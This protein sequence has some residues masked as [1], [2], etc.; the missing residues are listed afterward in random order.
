MFD[1][2]LATLDRGESAAISLVGEAGIGKTRLL[3]ELAR[4][5]DARGHVV[6]SGSG[7]DLEGD[8]PFRVFVDAMDDYL[9]SLESHSLAEL[10]APV[11]AELAT[12]FPALA[13]YA[14]GREVGLQQ[15]RYRS[16]RAVRELLA[17]LGGNRPLVL[18]LDDVHWADPGSIE[19]LTTMLHRPLGAPVLIASA[20]R[21]KQL[22][23]RLV[24]TMARAQRSGLLAVAELASFS[25]AE[26]RTFLGDALDHD[27]FYEESGGNPF[28][29]EQLARARHR[30]GAEQVGHAG[31]SLS[32][33]PVPSSVIASLVEELGMLSPDTRVVLDGASVVGD[34]FEPELAAAA[35]AVPDSAALDAI[36]ELLDLDLIRHTELPRRFRFRHPLMRRAVYESTRG[37]WRLAAHGRLAQALAALGA[38]PASRAHHVEYSAR[39]GDQAAIR[40]LREAG[41][42]TAARAPG[43]AARWFA[44]ALRLLGDSGPAPERVELRQSLAGAQ[45]ATGHFADARATLVEALREV[46]DGATAGRIGLIAAC[47]GVEQLLGQHDL[48]HERLTAA[49]DDLDDPLSGAAAAL[50]IS[51]AQAAF[52]RQNVIESRQWSLRALEAAE[53]VPDL[54]LIAAAAA[55]TAIAYAFEG[56]TDD[57]ERYRH[58][59]ATLIDAMSDEQLS[60][61]LDAIASLAGAESYLD[62]FEDSFA[63]GTRGLRIARETSQGDLLPM[64]VQA[65]ATAML[66]SGRLRQAVELLDGSIEAARLAGHNQTLAWSLLNRAFVAIHQ[67]ALNAARVDAQESIELARALDDSV[68]LTW[69]GLVMGFV[70]EAAGENAEAVATLL[71]AAAGEGLPLIPGVWRAYALDV[72]TRS[73]VTLGRRQKARRT[74]AHAD[75]VATRAD[76]GM[77]HAWAERCRA[78]LLLDAGESAEAGRLILESVGRCDAAGAVVEAA[79]SRV[80]AAR[81]LIQ[82][83][84]TDQA[85]T[86][87][88]GAVATYERC[89]VDRLRLEA[90]RELR[91][92]GRSVSRK[93]SPGTGSGI[94]ALTGRELELA[95]LVVDRR[96]NAEIATTLFLSPKTVEAHLTNIYRKLG[97]NSRV[98]L[99]RAIENHGGG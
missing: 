6:L 67:G 31:V 95:R 39:Q 13:T 73:L 7:S 18:I 26:A 21:P 52:Y 15:E 2:A 97:I 76:L 51:V 70:H 37:G 19:L 41:R 98:A 91:R 28:Y 86:E 10:S 24:S 59:A 22:P 1:E 81:A 84:D 4:Q 44:A 48:A 55:T 9:R 12:V 64:L 77:G 3:A 16:H 30:A 54:P 32:D 66:V 68:V 29:L 83:G 99:A 96:T 87:L 33:A 27:A 36:S 11:L 74:S 62:R 8:L 57:A 40:L 49:L 5:A 42:D 45:L 65:M 89:G 61:R 93:S 17:L 46:P 58:Q 72:L 56:A 34:P 82:M 53:H 38:A 20:Q 88:E 71:E 43:S 25:R 60:Q 80:I 47:A 50:S 14:S 75:E 69:A 63:H 79:K 94:A 85:A 90:E 92:L 78:A 35:A 23:D